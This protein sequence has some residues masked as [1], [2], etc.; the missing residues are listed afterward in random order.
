MDGRHR[1]DRER[2]VVDGRLTKIS[3]ELAWTYDRADWLGPVAHRPRPDRVDLT[4]T[5]VH[6]K[7][8]RLQPGIAASAVHQC[9]GTWDGRIVPTTV[10]DRRR[11]RL[12]RGGELALVAHRLLIPT[13]TP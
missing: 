13:D 2:A 12:G 11:R 6:D 4:F 9:F 3:E 1:H 8:G 5:P 7:V 10:P